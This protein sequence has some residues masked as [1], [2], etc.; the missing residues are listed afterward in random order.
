MKKLLKLYIDLNLIIFYIVILIG[1]LFIIY[2]NNIA[3]DIEG[4]II[5]IGISLLI[6]YYS[7]LP[8]ATEMYEKL[9]N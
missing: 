2:G 9:K 4:S 1:F 6:L 5:L 7:S 3:D 8:K